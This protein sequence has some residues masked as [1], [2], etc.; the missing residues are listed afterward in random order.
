MAEM[1]HFYMNYSEQ[2]QTYKALH[3]KE[4]CCIEKNDHSMQQAV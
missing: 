1:Q 3:M 4:T 2:T